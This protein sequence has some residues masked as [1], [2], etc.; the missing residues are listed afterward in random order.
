MAALTTMD[1]F[2]YRP[3]TVHLDWPLFK[4]R[5]QTFMRIQ[6]IGYVITMNNAGTDPLTAT[7]TTSMALNYLLHS[8]GEKILEIYNA[9]QNNENL[10]YVSFVAILDA[11]FT[12]VNPQIADY[13]FRA[14]K[15]NLNETLAD[16]AIRLKVLA[17][18]AAIN[19]DSMDSQVLSVIR[20]NTLDSETRMKCL[21][22]NTTLSNLLEWRK[23]HDLKGQCASLMERPQMAKAENIFSIKNDSDQRRCYACGGRYPHQN[24][25]CPARG[26]E[27][28]SCY[29]MNHMAIVCRNGQV[30]NHW[31]RQPQR[32]DQRQHND[33]SQRNDQRRPQ[34]FRQAINKYSQSA[35]KINASNEANQ[36]NRKANQQA[37][38]ASPSYIRTIQDLTEDELIS[39]FE[40]Y[41]R[42]RQV[43]S[44]KDDLQQQNNINQISLSSS[45]ADP[46]CEL[47]HEM[48]SSEIMAC[49]TTYITIG[50]SKIKLLIDTGTNLN[51]I[52]I[53]TYEGIKNKP[54]LKPT[55]TRAY[56]FHSKTAIPLMGEFFTIIK[57]KNQ[58]IQ[59]RYLVLNG[60][61][62]NILGYATAHA[63]GIIKIQSDQNPHII[64]KEESETNNIIHRIQKEWIHPFSSPPELFTGNLGLL[65][66]KLVHL[67]IDNTVKPCQ[68]P[69]YK[70]PFGLEE[71]TKEKLDYLEKN[72][73]ISKANGE[74]PSWIHP[75]QPV[76]KFDDKGK[77]S[78]V[79][80]TS[81][82][83]QF[84]KVLV[85]YKRNM[86]TI[87]E[88]TNSLAGSKWFS[89][90]DFK[91]AFNQMAY[92]DESRLLTAMATIWG[93]Y[94]WN[95]M[96]MGI[97][98]AS[99]IFQE[100]MQ[101]M[102]HDLDK[103]VKVALDDIM[104]H[105]ESKEE[106]QAILTAVLNRI[107]E[108]GMTL[109]KEKCAFLQKEVTFFG[110]TVSED[111]VRPK[112]SK[113]EDLQN[114]L[115]P[116]NIKEVHSFIGLTSYFKN[117][118]PYQSSLDRPLRD[119]L[120]K[121]AIFKWGSA[122]Q[123]AYSLLKQ[124]VMEEE[125]AFF[126]HRKVS[127][128][129]VDAGPDGCSSFLTQ[130]DSVKDSIKLVRCDS[131]AF[132]ASE[133]NYY[134]EKEAFAC[135]WACKTNHLYLYG[136][137]FFLITDA[138]S[139]KKIF[140]EDKTR[141]RVPIRFIR[142]K[143]DLSAYDVTF[144]HRAGS[145]NIADYLSRRFGP[146][147]SDITFFATK[148]LE[149][150]VNEITEA[151][152]PTNISMSDLIRSTDEDEQLA[153]IKKA[154][155]S[156]K[157][158]KSFG[159]ISNFRQIMSELSVSSHGIVLRND[160]IVI[161][162]NLQQK[163]IDYAH[164]GHIGLKLCKCLLRNICWFPKMDQMVEETIKDCVPCQ[165]TVR[166]TTTE[167]IMPTRI[168]AT[169]WHTIEIDFSSRTPTN[170]YLLAIYDQ[171]SR[172]NIQKISSDMT[173]NSAIRICQNLFAEYGVPKVIKSDNGPAF[174]SHTWAE[175]A[176]KYN[177]IHQKITPLHPESNA[178]AE[179][180]MSCT[181]KRIR[182]SMV[183]GTHWKVELSHY[184]KRYN[185]TPNSSTG[186]SPNMLLFGSDKC[187][188]LPDICTRKL[189]QLK[190]DKAIE[191]DHK[192]KAQ[193][194]RYADAYQHTR[195]RQ[196][197]IDDPVLHSWDRPNKHLPFFDP[198]PY[199]ITFIN[200]SMITATRNNH[201]IT[202]NSRHFKV[203]NEKCY[204]NALNLLKTIQIKP[205][206][207]KFIIY[208]RE[209]LVLHQLDNTTPPPTPREPQNFG[210]Q[211]QT[212]YPVRPVPLVTQEPLVQPVLPLTQEP[213]VRPVPPLTQE[214]LVRPVLPLT[215]EPLVRPV[216]PLTQE[217]LVQPV[218]P[219]T[220]E[221]L[222]L[223]AVNEE[224]SQA[225]THLNMEESTD[226]PPRPEGH[227]ME[228]RSSNKRGRL[229]YLNA[230]RMFPKSN[231]GDI[232]ENP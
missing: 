95:R 74:R 180:T 144:I 124:T 107:S 83:K 76:P 120:K 116:R 119:L 77:V 55:E 202:R 223:Q 73:I 98:T 137:H 193:M 201:I 132:S 118:S 197:Q 96:N 196:F 112:K 34:P 154:L 20:T 22:E 218:L 148:K 71:L 10:N 172:K 56:G 222:V 26:K 18:A 126:D 29:R 149:Q 168:P 186:F 184:L 231:L 62:T 75:C 84:N 226:L 140:E 156:I 220:H 160:V 111:G 113:I 21:D 103:N 164:E 143:S 82:A 12:A 37:T 88:L 138:L 70:V 195:H 175:F 194:K 68:Q 177:F 211:T 187:D 32:N 66:G 65:K 174:K 16:Y 7:E 142:W 38:V 89:K 11:R 146:K 106:G 43:E 167:P 139:V 153:A 215:H 191:N 200:G 189:T 86:P 23:A 90:L 108:S 125:M 2:V 9:T 72:G 122:E 100:T 3:D 92:D 207:L 105:S 69:A 102:F 127:E 27:C 64:E 52:S 134:L 213:L 91:D 185:Q 150:Q 31:Q 41:Y 50:Q 157:D 81:N 199:R 192:A 170:E 151:C 15:Q 232:I 147:N 94:Y 216:L 225:I 6:R 198:H 49:P 28:T 46:N 8:G 97:A 48:T 128:L 58:T 209:E 166:S 178:G 179:R 161:P 59:A 205:S 17:R 204:T 60:E 14:A 208:P 33:Q 229:S 152:R 115:P 182:C 35:N 19:A 214:P 221:P 101:A 51:I 130:I 165:C 163:V 13:H 117:R 219:L 47:I 206:S 131:H 78:S 25:F 129:Y 110:V 39:E 212:I 230:F 217:P 171:H 135:V 141:K 40:E 61:A 44:S 188:I 173:T 67:E 80:I 123:E 36:T 24:N 224:E 159:I 114:C 63:L 210:K 57:F 228:R 133:L 203:I 79:R 53:K 99:E 181:N 136:R 87:P 93:L 45:G 145:K 1:F 42:Q 190:I 85:R 169:A 162:K 183:A 30:G 4:Q 54:A 104:I 5:L 121:G 158:P 176:R 155:K 109:N 227:G